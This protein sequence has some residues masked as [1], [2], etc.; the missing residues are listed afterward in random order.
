MKRICVCLV[1]LILLG[2]CASKRALVSR[3]AEQQFEIAKEKY[4]QKKY[5]EA[6][7]EFYKVI[8]SHPGA[9]F[10][11]SAQFCLELC[12]YWEEDFSLA[13]AE[14]N[15]LLSSFPTS[16]LA[17]DAEYYIPLCNYHMSLG[18][19]LDQENT[20]LAIEGFGNFLDYYPNSPYVPRAKRYLLM[21]RGKLAEKAYKNAYIYT[22]LGQ[23]QPALM[24]LDEVLDKYGDTPWAGKA[25]FKI[26][27]IY[28]K[29]GE[30]SKALEKYEE[31]VE[32]FPQDEG[33]KEAKKRIEELEGKS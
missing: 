1:F 3:T 7:I 27:E 17:D 9:S 20:Q 8:F 22:K 29:Q 10:I 31:L 13:I 26:A 15:K 18:P 6:R 25:T 14:F 2:G 16:G 12:Y 24:Y 23:Y 33:V 5:D 21:A 4:K 11:D 19:T 30:L 32:K 28:Q